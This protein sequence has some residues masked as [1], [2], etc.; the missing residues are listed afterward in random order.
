M[1][2]RITDVSEPIDDIELQ[3]VRDAK[4]FSRSLVGIVASV[5]AGF[6]GFITA[7][8]TI[9]TGDY[10]IVPLT[11]GVVMTLVANGVVTPKLIGHLIE[12][13]NRKGNEEEMYNESEMSGGVRKWKKKKIIL[14]L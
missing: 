4:S 9:A 14:W 8:S 10:S 3:K 2:Y 13:Y 7:N 1:K 11:L 12:L 5:S 6:V